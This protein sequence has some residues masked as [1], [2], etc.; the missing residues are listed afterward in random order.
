MKQ[1]M[2]QTDSHVSEVDMC[3]GQSTVFKC[4]GHPTIMNGIPFNGY[5]NPYENGLSIPIAI[6][7]YW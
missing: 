7:Q 4:Y 2:S 5:T 3:H 6:P 1:H